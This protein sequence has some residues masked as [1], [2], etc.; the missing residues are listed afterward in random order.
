M[1]EQIINE[2]AEFYHGYVRQLDEGDILAILADQ[3]EEMADLLGAISDDRG[4]YRY[5]EGKWSI[6]E[7]FGHMID[8]ERVFTYRALCFARGDAGPFPGM[9]QDEYVAG[10]N[11]SA[12]SMQNLLMEYQ[13]Q[14]QATIAM[15][16]GL[17]DAALL[18]RGIASGVEFTAR[19]FQY[20]L[21]GHERHHLQVLRERYL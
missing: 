12:R 9:D 11:F 7:L 17:G 1:I 3:G 15:F 6:K 14:R 13:H 8:T 10:A 2:C 19:S 21:A 20:I 18:R 16:R 5:A 4:D